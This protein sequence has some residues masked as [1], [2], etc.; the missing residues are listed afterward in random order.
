MIYR[1]YPDNLL[2]VFY[3]FEDREMKNADLSNQFCSGGEH[4]NKKPIYLRKMKTL[5]HTVHSATSF[6]SLLLLYHYEIPKTKREAEG[7]I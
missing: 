4:V 3:V 5:L 7:D 2:N 6:I 1:Q